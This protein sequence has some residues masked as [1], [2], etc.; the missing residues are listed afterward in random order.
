[1]SELKLN[2]HHI[3]EALASATSFNYLTPS[4]TMVDVEKLT[5]ELNKYVALLARARDTIAYD[6]DVGEN[7]SIVKEI[8]AALKGEM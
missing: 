5:T 8:D 1:V 4:H 2:E 6:E 7:A 3:R